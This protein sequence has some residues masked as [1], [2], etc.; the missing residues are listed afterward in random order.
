MRKLSLI[1]L[2]LAATPILAHNADQLPF[3]QVDGLDAKVYPVPST[4]L[5]DFP[6]PQDLAANTHLT[7]ETV[8]VAIITQN[9]PILPEYVA[10][11]AWHWDFGDSQSADGLQ[12]SHAYAKPGSYLIELHSITAGESPQLLDRI[13]VNILP[14]AGYPLPKAVLT[15]DSQIPKNPYSDILDSTYGYS[16]HYDGSSSSGDGLSYFWDFGDTVTSANTVVDHTFHAPYLYV[17][18]L[19]RV[20]DKYGLVGDQFA[21]LQGLDKK[22]APKLPSS[23]RPLR[24]RNA[25][26]YAAVSGLFV[27]GVVLSLLRKRMKR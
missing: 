2:C 9:L 5:T 16:A 27:A 25:N 15:I 12:A 19:L 7:G 26:V 21:Q 8:K 17:S 3:V 23:E 24:F 13:Q 10:T 11:T 1:F 20:T 14:S 18:S 4:S 6:L 22:G